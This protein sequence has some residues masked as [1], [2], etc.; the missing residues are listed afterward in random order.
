MAS[1]MGTSLAFNKAE[2]RCSAPEKYRRERIMELIFIAFVGTLGLVVAELRDLFRR[3]PSFA[4]STKLSATPRLVRRALDEV[5][6]ASTDEE[7][8]EDAA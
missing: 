8:Y 4:A 3:R 6:A 7:R 1:M 2:R 5:R